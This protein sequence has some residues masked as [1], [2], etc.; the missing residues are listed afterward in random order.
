[1]AWLVGGCKL[2]RGDTTLGNRD[3]I[4]C[5]SRFA[6][7][8]K[9]ADS[10]TPFGGWCYLEVFGVV[11]VSCFFF[12]KFGKVLEVWGSLKSLVLQ[13]SKGLGSLPW[14]PPSGGCHFAL[15]D[16]VVWISRIGGVWGNVAVFS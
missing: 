3:P 15:L 4:V 9:N 13:S 7:A 6:L 12:S 10:V 8:C 16:V 14:V 5:L 2:A 1:M 11:V